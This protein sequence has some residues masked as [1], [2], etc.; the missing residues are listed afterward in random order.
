MSDEPRRLLDEGGDDVTQALLR[1]A[2][3]DVP[4]AAVRA[5]TIEQL[6]SGGAAATSEGSGATQGSGAASWK[7][8]AVSAAAVVL[9]G[10]YVLRSREP[11]PAPPEPPPPPTATAITTVEPPKVVEPPAP[12]VSA[13]APTPSV[14]ASVAVSASVSVAAKPAPSAPSVASAPSVPEVGLAEETKM[15]DEAR[16]TLGRNDPRGALAVLDRYNRTAK[17]RILG[18]EATMVRI[19]ALHVRGDDAAARALAKRFLAANPGSTYESRVRSLLGEVQA[20]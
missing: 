13:A 9:V 20:P 19:E 11:A 12:S 18:P 3:E 2:D 17:Q 1:S 6:G 7:W 16:S 14:T 4:D 15:L 10:A 5:R 8:I